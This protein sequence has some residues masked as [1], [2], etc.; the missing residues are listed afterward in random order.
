MSGNGLPKTTTAFRNTW[1][2][3][4]GAITLTLRIGELVC[5]IYFSCFL[6][7]S[8]IF[9]ILGITILILLLSQPE[10]VSSTL[11]E[12]S[13][14]SIQ[15]EDSTFRQTKGISPLLTRQLLVDFKIS[16]HLLSV[17]AHFLANASVTSQFEGSH[18]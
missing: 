13:S 12:P 1:S 10:T 2:A 8:A 18:G 7:N 6:D 17:Q 15:V 14:I 5:G 4:Q 16:G 11:I 3:L 9:Q